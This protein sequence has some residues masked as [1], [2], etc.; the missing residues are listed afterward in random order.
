MPAM[1]N[2]IP[3]LN[4]MPMQL[5][6]VAS[7]PKITYLGYEL[8]KTTLF[9]QRTTLPS[10]MGSNVVC[11]FEAMKKTMFHLSNELMKMKLNSFRNEGRHQRKF[12]SQNRNSQNWSI[13]YGSYDN[14]KI[15]NNSFI[16]VG[17]SKN[18]YQ[19]NKVSN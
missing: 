16:V 11:E 9:E 12:A 13:N 17:P 8:L 2:Q 15:E 19:N 1:P 14:I 18:G 3:M 6:V 4:P 7:L 5:V 10:K